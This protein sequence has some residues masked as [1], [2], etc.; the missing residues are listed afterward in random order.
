MDDQNPLHFLRNKIDAIDKQFIE[1][2]EQRLKIVAEIGLLKSKKGLPIYDPE[3]EVKMLKQR[4]MDAT[5]KDVPPE[6]IE[7]ILRR[8]MRESYTSEND[9][10]FTQVN[11]N[12]GDIV[13]IGGA[14]QMGKL[15]TQMFRLSGYQ[16]KILDK[17]DWKNAD[18]IFSKAG[19]VI[20]SV[21]IDVTESVIQKLSNLPKN[22]ILADL[23]SI[24]TSPM[25]A[26]L[27]IHTGPV[28]GM[29]P[30]FGPDTN[31]LAKQVIVYCN[32]RFPGTYLWL[33]EQI[34]LWGV[35]L[36]SISPEAHDKAMTLIQALRHFSSFTYG[37]HLLAENPKIKELLDLSSPIYRL[38]LAMVGRLFAQDPNLY[39]DI[40][41][42]SPQNT[43]MIRRYHDRFG[44]AL[45]YLENNDRQ[46]FIDTF[47]KVKAWF[48]DYADQFLKESESRL[49]LSNDQKN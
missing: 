41:F 9:S 39:A 42:S 38:E 37:A 36:I 34:S 45:D 8:I 32:G 31:S 16:V 11:P 48:G 46:A 28:I 43:Q 18:S 12:L 19:L 22:C 13:I 40:I 4:R 30:M 7:D 10:G 23:T 20:V 2:L 25:K 24:K 21:P 6:L 29:H 47:Q 3:R 26:M 44:E 14:G 49:K 5:A 1:L 35:N 17:T 15:F 33:I 27:N